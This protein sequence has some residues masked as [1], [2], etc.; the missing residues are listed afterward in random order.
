MHGKQKGIKTIT[1]AR[2]GTI[3]FLVAS[4]TVVLSGLKRSKSVVFL[5]AR[6]LSK[7][8]PGSFP[9]RSYTKAFGYKVASLLPTISEGVRGLRE[10]QDIVSCGKVAMRQ[11]SSDKGCSSKCPFWRA[12]GFTDHLKRALRNRG[13]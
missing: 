4:P 8:Y 5:N 13:S 6:E 7:S 12:F 2:L 9:L 1:E 10:P 3:V 11:D